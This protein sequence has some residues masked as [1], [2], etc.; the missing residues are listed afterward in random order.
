MI[1]YNITC[2]VEAAAEKNWLEWVDPQLQEWSKSENLKST[3]LLQLKSNIPSDEVIYAL[4]FHIADPDILQKF[5]T[6]EE[7][8]IK[9]EVNKK[10]GESV[11]HLSSQLQILKEYR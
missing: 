6:K 5:L 8:L 9:E 3:T 7:P 1:L 4:Q 10:F 2:N 11:L